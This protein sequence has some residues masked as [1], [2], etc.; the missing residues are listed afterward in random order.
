MTLQTRTRYFYAFFA[1]CGLGV[2]CLLFYLFYMER[3]LDRELHTLD[4]TRQIVSDF[5]TA[6]FEYA[7]HRDERP[8]TQAKKGIDQLRRQLDH[9]RNSPSF[10]GQASELLPAWSEAVALLGDSETLLDQLS[11]DADNPAQRERDRRTVKLYLLRTQ[12]MVFSIN[13]FRRTLFDNILDQ[14]RLF[15]E[16]IA[17]IVVALLALMS[18]ALALLQRAVMR[19]LAHMVATVK[20]VGEGNLNVRLY[21]KQND[22]FGQLGRAFDHMMDEIQAMTVSRASLEAEVAERTRAEEEAKTAYRQLQEAQDQ[23]LQMEKLSALGTLVGGVAHEINN[24]LMG[25]KSYLAYAIDRMDDGRPKE[26]LQRAS[27]EVD[28]IGRIVK[29]MLV[30]ARSKS[31]LVIEEV[32]LMQAVGNTLALID[33]DLRHQEIGITIDVPDHPV[34]ACGNLDN[35]QQALLNVFLNARDALRERPKPRTLDIALRETDNGHCTICIA[36][37]GPGVPASIRGR[38]FD[39]FFTTKTAG[40]GTGLGLAVSS[41]IIAASGGTIEVEDAPMGGA[42][43][44]ITLKRAEKAGTK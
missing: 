22:E 21:A 25:I 42:L 1:L 9:I 31:T 14:Y 4:E 44:V 33:A 24:P 29:N 38:I 18:V 8:L 3:L 6:G 40:Q 7:L 32:D 2:L 19:P 10:Q 17:A 26:M 15:R 28:R 16:G 41:Q 35:L 37:N 12:A 34:L 39:P 23:M 13:A 30:F 5:R 11:K 36:D 27:S 43:F 20:S